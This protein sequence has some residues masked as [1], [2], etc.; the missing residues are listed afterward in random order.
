[1]STDVLR[2]TLSLSQGPILQGNV[3]GAA[4]QHTLEVLRDSRRTAAMQFHACE[5]AAE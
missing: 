4:T 2:K 5:C 1:M 3:I